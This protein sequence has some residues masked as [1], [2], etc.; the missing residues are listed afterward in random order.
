MKFHALYTHG[1][2]NFFLL[3]DEFD[4]QIDFDRGLFTQKISKLIKIDGTLFLQKSKLKNCTG[5]MSMYNTDGSEAE[6]CGNGIRIV[7]RKLYE[8]TKLKEFN[9]ETKKGKILIKKEEDIYPS[10][11]T[12]SA[13]INP[14]NLKLSQIPLNCKK[15]QLLN[16]FCPESGFEDKFSA[17]SVQNPHIIFVRKNIEKKEL[18]KYGKLANENKNTFPNGINVN[19]VEIIKRNKIFVQTYERGVG[20]TNSCGTGMSSTSFIVS[21]LNYCD[22]EN[23]IEVL[24]EGGKVFCVTHKDDKSIDLIGNAT[25][26]EKYEI[27]YKDEDIKIKVLKIFENEIKKYKEF[28]NN[29]DN[30]A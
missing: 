19:F 27:T 25:Y 23:K 17:I 10:I 5:K 21:L 11:L 6:M 24:N 30:K 28:I 18:E 13:N 8:R 29:L 7:A 26:I 16:D 20:I 14:V 12:F 2:K 4:L 3:I 1:S 22:F 15:E 9:I